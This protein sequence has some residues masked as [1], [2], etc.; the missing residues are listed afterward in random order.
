MKVSIITCTYNSAKTV[1]DALDSLVS[2]NYDDIE[3]IVIDGASQDNTL[4]VVS[5]YKDLVS[6]VVSEADKGIY[7]ALNKGIALATGDVIG[8]LHSDDILASD[9]VISR[10]VQCF[11]P[12]IDAVYGDL[13]YVERANTGK[14]TRNWI[15]KPF[16]R[17]LFYYG[18]MPAHPTF[19]LR[20]NRYR[21]F[22]VFNLDFYTSA[23]YELL[24]RM[25]FK[26]RLNAKYLP[27]VMTK[28][29]VGGQSNATLKNRWIANKE[30]ARAW[31][32]NGIKARFYTRW[33]KPL[34]KIT[35]FINT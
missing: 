1:G 18:W 23:D 32:V 29:R 5:S 30:D 25:L 26:H 9:D 31:R 6:N 15:G 2:Q 10:V 11:D 12:S 28:M 16:D 22:G 13:Q 21:E 17:E 14:A 35:Q 19:Y 7:D 24:L 20:A 8:I 3:S 4:E 33:L 34:S 27:M